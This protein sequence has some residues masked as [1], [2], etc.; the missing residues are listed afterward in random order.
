MPL[1]FIQKT[2]LFYL[3][4]FSFAPAFASCVKSLMMSDE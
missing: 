1:A 2:F 4:F 3:I